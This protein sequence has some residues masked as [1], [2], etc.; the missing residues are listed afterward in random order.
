MLRG[1]LQQHKSHT[2]IGYKKKFEYKHIKH[3]DSYCRV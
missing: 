1:A 3:S 2:L